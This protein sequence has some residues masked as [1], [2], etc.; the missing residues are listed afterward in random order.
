MTPI[1]AAPRPTATYVPVREGAGG[2]AAGGCGCVGMMSFV[3]RDWAV[4]SG[5]IAGSGCTAVVAEVG[6][7]AAGGFV[8][9]L[10]VGVGVVAVVGDAADVG[11][12]G[13]AI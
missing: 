11:R 2:G 7:E 1:A 6:A 8:T 13:C 12:L 3:G 9:L 5:S 10:T 4:D